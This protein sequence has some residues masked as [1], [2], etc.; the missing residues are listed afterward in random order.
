MIIG[1]TYKG[2][3]HSEMAKKID[4][5]L[6]RV[7]EPESNLSVAQLGLVQRVRYNEE[8]KKFY[9]FTNTI[10]TSHH[11]CC[12]IIQGLLVSSTFERLTEEFQKEFPDISI[13][14]V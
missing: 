7:K 4:A 9:V 13:E 2:M 12:T 1:H 11:Y 8:Y 10:K 3:L 6:E 14:F 5:V